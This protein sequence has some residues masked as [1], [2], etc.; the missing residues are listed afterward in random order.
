MSRFRL[1]TMTLVASLV[2]VPVLAHEDTPRDEPPLPFGLEGTID[3][4]IDELKPALRDMM[5]IVKSFEGIDDPRYYTMPEVLPNGDI[6]IR[7]RE[8][9]P[10]YRG[11]MDRD[12]DYDLM[13]PRD[14]K[15]ETKT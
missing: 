12:R 10:A 8:D 4:M 6:I 11:P 9:A 1:A 7:R 13:P 15:D 2:A 5:D 3:R 14:P